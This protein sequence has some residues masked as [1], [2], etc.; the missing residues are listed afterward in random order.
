MKYVS[1]I[2]DPRHLLEPFP[3]Y[4]NKTNVRQV[5]GN[6]PG[7]LG[8]LG[9]LIDQEDPAGTHTHSKVPTTAAAT[10]WTWDFCPTFMPRSIMTS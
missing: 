7:V 9:I 3:V 4:V 10:L 5:R 6:I 2:S 8:F 1:K